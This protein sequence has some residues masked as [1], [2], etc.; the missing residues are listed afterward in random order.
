MINTIKEKFK[1]SPVIPVLT[2]DDIDTSLKVAD[3]L[4]EAGLTNLEVTLRTTNALKCIEAIKKEF[5]SANIG[6]GTIIEK[7]QFQQIK[8]VGALFAVSPGWSINLVNE[9]KKVGIAYL[10]GASTPSEIIS[11]FEAGVSFQKFFHASQSGGYK[12]L[13]AYSNIFPQISFCPTG[14]ISKKD[15]KNYLE[16]DNVL[17]LGGSWM[18]SDKDILEKNYGNIENI[19]K[20]IMN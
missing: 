10:P 17:C 16:L 1:N 20:L 19:A 8:D 13:K 7:K 15:F 5:P 14:G 3:I 6:A 9:A 12:M 4:I 2:L 18:V 11:L